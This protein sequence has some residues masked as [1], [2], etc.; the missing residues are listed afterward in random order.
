MAGAPR[1]GGRHSALGVIWREIRASEARQEEDL[2]DVQ[3]ALVSMEARQ[4]EDMRELRNR[5]MESLVTSKS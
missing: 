4:R 2:H 3:N 1:G 5:L